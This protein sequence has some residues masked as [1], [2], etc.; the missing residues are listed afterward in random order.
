MGYFSYYRYFIWYH[1]WLIDI[2]R[3]DIKISEIYK[4][5]NQDQ[6]HI[7][8]VQKRRDSF[9]RL[10]I[11]ISFFIA[12]HYCHFYGAELSTSL[13]KVKVSETEKA[14]TSNVRAFSFL[15]TIYLLNQ[16]CGFSFDLSFHSSKCNSV[17][18]SSLVFI[19]P[20]LCPRFTFCPFETDTPSSLEYT[21]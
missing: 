8:V 19:L 18:P 16:V 9:Q 17:L 3:A 20:T 21:V 2:R 6:T 13:I 15:N 7:Y 1:F 12:K 5:N 14:R 10:A 4:L 11:C